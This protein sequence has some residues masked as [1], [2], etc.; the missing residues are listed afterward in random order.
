VRPLERADVCTLSAAIGWLELGNPREAQTEFR[1]ISRDARS[2]P[3]TLDVEWRLRAELR[4]WNDALEVARRLIAEDPENPSGWIHQSYTLHELKRTPEA[5]QQLLS[6][7]DTF[8]TIPTVA[9]NLACYACQLDDPTDARTWLDRA[10]RL[11]G[12]EKIREMALRDPDLH[13]LWKEIADW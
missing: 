9:Y 6:V 10:V 13:P 2:H 7:A 3:D 5:R 8:S 12:K 1:H 4:E 11:A